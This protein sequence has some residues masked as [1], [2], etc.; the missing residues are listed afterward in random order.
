[1]ATKIWP[2]RHLGVSEFLPAQDSADLC[3]FCITELLIF[4]QNRKK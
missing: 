2:E 3:R 1:M 4:Y